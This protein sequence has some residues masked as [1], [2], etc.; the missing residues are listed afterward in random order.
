LENITPNQ[1]FK[2]KKSILAQ[3]TYG[4]WFYDI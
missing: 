3:K 1:S 2:T 4:N